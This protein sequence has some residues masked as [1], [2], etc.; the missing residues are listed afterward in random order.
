MKILLVNAYDLGGA[1]KACIRLHLGLIEL[2]ISSH[3]LFKESVYILNQSSNF[4][5][6]ID[7]RQKIR[8]KI[9]LLLKKYLN[10]QSKYDKASL[11]LGIRPKGL[12][13]F[14]FPFSP[15]DLTQSKLYNDADII[16]LHWVANFLDWNSFFIKNKKPVIWTLHDENPFTGGEHYQEKFFGIDKNGN[17][18]PRV[19]LKEEIH[20][21]SKILSEKKRAIKSISNLHIVC[22]SKWLLIKSKNS[23]LF[24][25]F[26]H[27]LIQYGFPTNIYKLVSKVEARTKLS[28]PID[29][30]VLLFVADS[31]SNKRKGFEFLL[32]ALKRIEKS[33]MG[34]ILLCSVGE[35]E[36]A[37]NYT[38][39]LH[40][41][42]ID[43]EEIIALIYSA[44]NFFIIPSLE[45]NLPNTMIESLL[46]GTPVVG[47]N[48]GGIP[49]VI[50]DGINGF[51]CEEISVDGLKKTIE[52]AVHN[53]HL[54]NNKD[55]AIHAK[56]KF[57]L[58]KQATAYSD[59][60]KTVLQQQSKF[61]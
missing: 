38:N 26:P 48:I 8:F 16:H 51:L 1:A 28:I 7:F 42:R 18:I 52:K 23:S 2:N 4:T 15:Y 30:I 35:G 43:D 34:N 46:C 11:F 39:H 17:P 21:E 58:K 9:N 3:L 59:L 27:H 45:D 20:M 61:I 6:K 25:R 22:P 36:F 10:I 44:A 24:K 5:Q 50:E 19:Y 57:D 37:E 60:Y 55:I 47:F 40:F 32:N 49:D 13:M 12:E 54:I 29:K 56:N 31:I 41:G 33:I 14:S 53:R